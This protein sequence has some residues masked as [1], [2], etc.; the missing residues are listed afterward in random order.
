MHP[1]QT[2]L[3][4]LLTELGKLPP[5]TNL[6]V[7]LVNHDHLLTDNTINQG[8][9]W[10]QVIIVLVEDPTAWPNAKGTT[11]ITS[12]TKLRAAQKNKKASGD[13]ATNFFLFLQLENDGERH[14]AHAGY[15]TLGVR[16]CGQRPSRRAAPTTRR[17]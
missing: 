10:W 7:P 13:V 9:E 6:Y 14:G 11:G 17:R 15:V 3:G 1:L 16:S 8:S 2:D 5:K 12:I 4:P